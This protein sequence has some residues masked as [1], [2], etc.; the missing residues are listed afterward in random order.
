M[1][2]TF[3]WKDIVGALPDGCVIPARGPP[4][5]ASSDFLALSVTHAEPPDEDDDEDGGEGEGVVADFDGALSPPPNP[6]GSDAS[7]RAST[8]TPQTNS[9][10]EMTKAHTDRTRFIATSRTST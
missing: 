7:A 10:V 9:T 1:S 6:S 5:H 2:S 8:A 3:E 4:G